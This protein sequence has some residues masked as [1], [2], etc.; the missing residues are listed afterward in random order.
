M[1]RTFGVFAPRP[2]VYTASLLFQQASEEPSSGVAMTLG[3][4]KRAMRI[5]ST[6]LLGLNESSRPVLQ[7][8]IVNATLL[9]FA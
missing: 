6:Y 4:P 3:L 9:Q 5:I 1:E 2:V 7:C 8:K